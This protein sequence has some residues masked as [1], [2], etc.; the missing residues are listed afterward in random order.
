LSKR[1]RQIELRNF[2]LEIEYD[3]KMRPL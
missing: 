3:E 1:Y 2:L